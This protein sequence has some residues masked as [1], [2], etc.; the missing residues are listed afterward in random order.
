MR[1]SASDCRLIIQLWERIVNHRNRVFVLMCL[2]LLTAAA[3][4][5]KDYH[6]SLQG[7]DSNPGMV[8]KPL[9]TISAA[10][11]IAQP[12]D[13][14]IVH[15]GVYR[16][17]I[18]PPRGGKSDTERIVYQAAKGEAVVLKGSERVKGWR[19]V[20]DDTWQ[21][22]LPGDYFGGFNPYN[23]RI[24]GDWFKPK[25]REHHTGAVYLNGHWLTE[26]ATRDEVLEPVHDTPLWFGKV[27]PNGTTRLWAQFKGVN[28]NE[29]LVEINAR[30]SVF[31]PKEKGINYITVSG[32]TLEHA[33]TPWAP[34]T[35]E[36]VG[37]I[38][39]HW[40]KGWIIEDNTIR[41]ATCVG[42]TLGKYGDE[43]DNKSE[44]ADAYNRT[45][46]R[47]LENGW[48]RE[49]VGS[50]IVRNNTISH[51][52]QAGIVGSLGAI[53]SQVTD[54]HIFNIWK[55][56]LFTGHEMAGIKLHAP[57]DVLIQNNCIHDTGRGIWL[58]WMTQGTRVT[59]NLLFNN[60]TD[61]LY[62]EVSHGPYVVDNNL[63]LSTIAFKDCS[64]GGAFAHNLFAGEITRY[65]QSRETPYHP[66]HATEILG[67]SNIATGDN[68]FYNNLFVDGNGLAVYKDAAM[69][70]FI[71]GNT[72]LNG[73]APYPEE[74]NNTVLSQFNPNLKLAQAGD[75]FNL[76]IVLP[77][78][79]TDRNRTLVTSQRLGSAAIPRAP[80]VNYDGKPLAIKHDYFSMK[81]NSENPTPG[82][83]AQ[84]VE[85][86]HTI[87][88]WPVC[89]R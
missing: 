11:T 32:F 51:C 67:L 34:P 29:A 39:T 63:F 72:Y 17:R 53:F 76:H 5:A 38:G 36:Q 88:V 45:I 25:G 52:E 43:W 1:F 7:S 49:Q 83:F 44:S 47:A 21:V 57:I 84:L 85:G 20:R 8:S 59:Q 23:D 28:P 81:R 22:T 71:N 24:R 16:E 82:P 65:P 68:R 40:S 70:V 60:S 12:G 61:D 75:A 33:A 15:K 10:A 64:Q 42:V 48:T 69:P 74:E 50:H 56:R 66:P 35:A 30:Q 37:L 79:Q 54:N 13:R 86:E 18:N 77:V 73:A 9:K 31:Y 58:D 27:D 89:S 19:A 41:Y 46:Q 87:K 78:T 3:G 4:S 26:A 55:K 14:I 62:V 6:V 80:F 2:W